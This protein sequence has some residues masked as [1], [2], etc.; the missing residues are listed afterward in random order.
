MSQHRISPPSCSAKPPSRACAR[1][2]RRPRWHDNRSKGS[3]HAICR[4]QGLHRGGGP[5]GADARRSTGGQGL[6]APGRQSR[7]GRR[8]R[9]TL[10]SSSARRPEFHPSAP[11]TRR[12][13]MSSLIRVLIPS[14]SG[15]AL[16]QAENV[17]LGKLG[18]ILRLPNS[19]YF[20]PQ[21]LEAAANSRSRSAPRV[22]RA[23]PCAAATASSQRHVGLMALANSNSLTGRLSRYLTGF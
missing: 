10:I 12:S 11:A 5:E 21:L 6:G 15:V 16:R 18:P 4:E 9:W 14:R 3:A 2:G 23:T 7:C 13:K 20:V 8:D 19:R 1:V 17:A 22:P